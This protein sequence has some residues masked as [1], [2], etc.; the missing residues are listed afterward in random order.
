MQSLQLFPPSKYDTSVDNDIHICINYLS[1]QQRERFTRFLN[2]LDWDC[3]DVMVTMHL[4]NATEEEITA[5]QVE[6]DMLE[7]VEESNEEEEV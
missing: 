3:V 4:N 1:E 2:R 5:T 7:M 6:L